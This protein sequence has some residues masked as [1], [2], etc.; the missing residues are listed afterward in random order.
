M[1]ESNR[2]RSFGRWLWATVALFGLFWA[3]GH[4]SSIELFAV[5]F[6]AVSIQ[7]L[8]VTDYLL[9]ASH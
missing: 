9:D 7:T 8:A 6:V 3:V 1:D 5:L 2:M 4:A